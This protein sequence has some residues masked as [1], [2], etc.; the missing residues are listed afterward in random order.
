MGRPRSADID[1]ATRERLLQ[2]AAR[3]FG[4]SGY[5]ARL[6]DIAEA[7]G[8]RRSSLLYHFRSKDELYAAVIEDA[9]RRLSTSLHT[10]FLTTGEFEERLDAL[11]QSL[12]GFEA[13]HHALLAV[14]TRSLLDQD[15][16]GH[17]VL[18]RSF[19]P[20]VDQLEAFV[21]KGAGARLS[22]GFPVRAAILQLMVAHLVRSAMGEAGARLWKGE[23]HSAALARAVLLGATDSIKKG[24]RHGGARR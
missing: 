3:A 6:E 16:F 12:V 21:R 10:V 17:A 2:A 4:D 20:L 5:G 24:R 11:V 15:G 23:A 19:L 9:F 1:E 7:A 13:E 18:E 14:V 22:R 8:I